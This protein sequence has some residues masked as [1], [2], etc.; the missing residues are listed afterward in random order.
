M[1]EMI[2]ISLSR[3]AAL[4]GMVIVIY[5]AALFIIF[6]LRDRLRLKPI[7]A[8]TQFNSSY[9][10]KEEQ[11]QTITSDSTLYKTATLLTDELKAFF[12]EF[13]RDDLSKEELSFRLRKI[14]QKYDGITEPVKET[15]NHYI[16]ISVAENYGIE[17]S[18]EE[19]HQLHCP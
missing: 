16:S 10:V 18:D 6:K 19:L 17:F 12:A 14:L 8:P 4:T 2:Q 13:S 15:I 3:Y 11:E 9:F 7:A 5:Y 1:K